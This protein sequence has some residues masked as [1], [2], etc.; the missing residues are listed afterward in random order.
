MGL[1][2]IPRATARSPEPLGERDERRELARDRDRAGVDEHRREVIGRHVAV[3]V[4]ERDA[5]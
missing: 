5:S 2:R 4:G 3:E 1:L